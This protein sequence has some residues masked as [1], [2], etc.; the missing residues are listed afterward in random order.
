MNSTFIKILPSP[1]KTK[2]AGVYFKEIQQTTIDAQGQTKQT[3]VDKVYIIRYRDNGKARFVTLGK[4]SEGIREAYCKAKRNEFIILAKNGELPP[5]I[6]KRKSKDKAVTVNDVFDYYIKNKDM[7]D[8]SRYGFEG[9]YNKHL[10]EA[11]GDVVAKDLTSE[12]IIKVRDNIVGGLKTKDVVIQIISAMFNYVITKKYPDMTNPIIRV[13]ALDRADDSKSTKKKKNIQRERYL[14]SDD[15]QQLREALKD[16]FLSLLAVEILL[17]TGV[18]VGGAL[19]I[20][21]ID[22][23]L[24]EDTIKLIDHKAGGDTYTGFISASLK[25]LLVDHLPK[26]GRNDFVLSNDGTQTSYEDI[27]PPI[28]KV[29]DKLF[30]EGLESKDSQNRIVIHSL[31]HTFASL[32]ASE[33]VPLYTIKELLN[34]A[35]ISMTMRYAKLSKEAGQKAVKRLG[36]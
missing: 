33:N 28:K 18:R 12:H 36:L 26:L 6:E 29:F 17:S 5:M 24:S 15:I 23:D 1:I 35:N 14:K 10:R 32:L 25:V 21:K 22:I 31:R 11:I 30:N 3:I 7:T 34:H 13:R 19:T 2:V 9:R 27:L 20:K 16:D 4:Y 8:K